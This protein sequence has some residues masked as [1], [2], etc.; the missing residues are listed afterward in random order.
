MGQYRRS[1]CPIQP[2]WTLFDHPGMVDYGAGMGL[3]PVLI[4]IIPIVMIVN[5]IAAIPAAIWIKGHVESILIPV[6]LCTFLLRSILNPILGGI[7]IVIALAL[8]IV[9]LL[10]AAATNVIV[11]RIIENRER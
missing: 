1:R 2:G 8:V 6:I 3:I 10:T 7:D 9:G 11:I 4:Q 5:A